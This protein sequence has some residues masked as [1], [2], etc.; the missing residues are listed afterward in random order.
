MLSAEGRAQLHGIDR[1]LWQP[2]NW[3][4]E[5]AGGYQ[6]LDASVGM[7]DVVSPELPAPFVV[8]ED[9]LFEG[10]EYINFYSDRLVFTNMYASPFSAEGLGPEGEFEVAVG[11]FDFFAYDSHGHTAVR[12]KTARDQVRS[13]MRQSTSEGQTGLD[14]FLQVAGRDRTKQGSFLPRVMRAVALNVTS[15]AP[16]G[17]RSDG[18]PTERALLKLTEVWAQDPGL[19]AKERALGRLGLRGM[20][21]WVSIATLGLQLKA[22]FGEGLDRTVRVGT[23]HQAGSDIS[24]K[25][26]ILGAKTSTV[27]LGP[28]A[29]Q[30]NLMLPMMLATSFVP[31]AEL[32]KILARDASR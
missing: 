32:Q 17:A 28:R 7:G 26:G 19:S 21:D 29:A 30:P 22:H 1:D 11:G 8:D 31:E 2:A 3:S 5:A 16:I 9:Q 10:I 6:L 14:A 20:F 25:L 18:T 23:L 27:Y 13:Q 12:D 15:D 24:R 4:R